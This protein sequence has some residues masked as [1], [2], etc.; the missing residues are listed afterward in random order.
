MN[1]QQPAPIISNN[2]LNAFIIL[3]VI[4]L[5]IQVI[6]PLLLL[7][8]QG[9]IHRPFDNGFGRTYVNG[10]EMGMFAY[11]IA[12]VIFAFFSMLN[13]C[14]SEKSKAFQV[15]YLIS[16][17][18][19]SFFIFCDSLK[20]ICIDSCGK[21]V[22]INTATGTTAFI[23]YLLEFWLI[24]AS[25]IIVSKINKTQA[26]LVATS[27]ALQEARPENQAENNQNSQ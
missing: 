4:L 11:L 6:I 7:T 3:Q 5:V 21:Y 13:I 24:I 10:Y 1:P 26:Q 18:V 22:L 27:S 17:I 19:L 12:S 25:L 2:K 14:I 15:I 9:Y 23:L 16:H 20:N 8:P